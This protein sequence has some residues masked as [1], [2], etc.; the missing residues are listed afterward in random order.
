MRLRVKVTASSGLNIRNGPSTS[1]EVLGS[2]SY[3]EEV[4]VNDTGENGTWYRLEDGGG[5][6][7]YAAYT[8]VVANLEESTPP[9]PPPVAPDHDFS[10]SKPSP[11]YSAIGDMMDNDSDISDYDNSLRGNKATGRPIGYYENLNPIKN[12]GGFP[13]QAGYDSTGCAI[14]NYAMDTSAFK[15][16]LGIMKR[17]LNMLSDDQNGYSTLMVDLFTK[18]NRFKIEHPD[19]HLTKSFSYVFFTRP[20]LNIMERSGKS[21]FKLVKQVSNDPV[22][23]YLSK[24]NPRILA[25]L[26]ADYDSSHDFQ[27]FLSN[28]AESFELSDEYV[29]TM[30]HGETFTGFRVMYGKNNIESRTAGTFSVKYT[31][32]QE[33]SVY[34]THKAWIDYISKVYRGELVS[35]PEYIYKRILD[36]ACSVYYIICAADGETIL[37]WSKYYG[38]FPTNAPSSTQSWSKGNMVKIPEYNI[39]YAYAYK[40]D[41]SPLSLAEFNMNSNGKYKYRRIYEPDM[42]STGRSMVGAP[43]IETSTESGTGAYV[44]KLKFRNE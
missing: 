16:N 41:F 38:V 43:F 40:E 19:Y 32:D 26:I 44:F 1:E 6:Y 5:M 13:D 2:L 24:N 17:N 31:D 34:K 39:T 21:N 15:T 22:Y 42:L 9:S 12:R 4:V 11:D 30:E 35:K 20:D 29:K 33:F 10:Q 27:P 36:Y 3:G 28:R 37:F 14:Y 23:Y 7:I 18:F 8:E 25:S